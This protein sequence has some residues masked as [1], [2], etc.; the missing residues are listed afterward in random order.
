MLILIFFLGLRG[1]IGHL[2]GV[3]GACVRA[4]SAPK[5]QFTELCTEIRE[6]HRYPNPLNLLTSSLDNRRWEI[7]DKSLESHWKVVMQS[8]LLG[9]RLLTVVVTD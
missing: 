2:V 8:D 6:T 3:C 7:I 1:R 9:H 4:G 5:L